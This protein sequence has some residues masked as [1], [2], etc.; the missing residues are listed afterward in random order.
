M[1]RTQGDTTPQDSVVLD[2]N[3]MR[4]A[5]ESPAP[6][7]IHGGRYGDQSLRKAQV[8][9]TA[10][11]QTGKRCGACRLSRQ[12]SR[13]PAPLQSYRSQSG[14]AV[15]YVREALTTFFDPYSQASSNIYQFIA[16]TAWHSASPPGPAPS[17]L[18]PDCLPA[19]HDSGEQHE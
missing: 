4:K 17:T 14:A 16:E 2:P 3:S 12:H 15:V 13:P 7:R 9:S 11:R 6:V 10:N 5:T 18:F 1:T 19:D 8:L